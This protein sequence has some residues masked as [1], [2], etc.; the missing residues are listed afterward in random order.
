V[1][2]LPG[3]ASALPLLQLYVEGGTYN[4]STE[5]WEYTT[6]GDTL[7]LWTIGNVA[8][9]GGKGA[10]L[11]VKLAIAYDAPSPIGDGIHFEVTSSQTVGYRGFQDPTLAT[12]ATYLRTVTDGSTPK[13][14]DGQNLPSHGEYGPGTHWQEFALGDFT[15]TTSSLTDFS[16]TGALAPSGLGGQIN[17]YEITAFTYDISK[18]V[19]TTFH[20]DL[21]DHYQSK[22]KV[23]SVF[24]P[25]SHDAQGTLTP[26]PEPSTLAMG[27]IGGVLALCGLRRLRKR[28]AA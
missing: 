22:T 19:P 11:G 6:T 5:T 23:S 20:F 16:G 15:E 13:L 7:R 9:G 25:F 17:V 24:A 4:R 2:L 21:Y 26:I 10:I 12:T 28:A 8:G 14:Y 27:C 3:R 18:H 1:A